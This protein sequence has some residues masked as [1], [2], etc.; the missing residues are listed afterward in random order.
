M[1]CVKLQTL[2]SLLKAKD[3]RHI[4]SI[5]VPDITYVVVVV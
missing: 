5:V 3:E 2:F 1:S 4:V